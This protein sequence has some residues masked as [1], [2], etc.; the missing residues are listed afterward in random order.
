M[1]E[2]TVPMDAEERAS[3]ITHAL[4]LLLSIAG[5]SAIIMN[6]LSSNDHWKI[7]GALLFSISLVM[8]YTASTLYHGVRSPELKR[9]M[10]IFDH[11]AIYC[12]IAGCYT[13]FTL[14]PLRGPLGWTLFATVWSIAALGIVF[15]LFYTGKFRVLSTLLYLAMGW[16]VVFAQEPI[17]AILPHEAISLIL[18]GGISYT[19]GALIYLARWPL[20]HHAIWHL[21][22]MAG[23]A[24]HYFAVY[25]YVC[26]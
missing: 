6:A 11:C 7:A 10:K 18:A 20:F 13:P 24:F 17:R 12:L 26:C 15:K 8:L 22:V 21:F 19:V 2:N 1:T 5:A 4:G 3:L 14:V 25:F 23:S 16:L 9:R